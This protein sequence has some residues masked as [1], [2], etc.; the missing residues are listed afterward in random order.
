VVTDALPGSV[1]LFYA[2]P[3]QGSRS[4]AAGVVTCPLGVVLFGTI[5]SVTIVVTTTIDLADHRYGD[6]VGHDVRP[7]TCQRHGR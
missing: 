5:A 7:R 4:P 1:V 2:M 3:S 6:R